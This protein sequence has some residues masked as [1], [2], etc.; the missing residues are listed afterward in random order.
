MAKRYNFTSSQYPM[1]DYEIQRVAPSVFTDQ[2]HKSTSEKFA[3]ITTADIL[4]GLRGEGWNVFGAG[5]TFAKTG[6]REHTKHMLRLRH[7]GDSALRLSDNQSAAEVVLINAH[8]GTS[9]YRMLGGM[10]VFA[11]LNGLVRPGKD[12]MEVRV[13]HSGSAAQ[14]VVEGAFTVL[15]GL[16]RVV[17]ER[18]AMR[19]VTLTRDEQL[20]FARSALQLTHEAGEAP[21]EPVQLLVP[22]RHVDSGSDLWSVFNRVQENTIKGG[23]RGFSTNGRRITTRPVQAIDRSVGLNQALWTLADEMRKLKTGEAVTLEAV[24]A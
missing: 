3:Q 13:R 18:D 15:D 7:S 8:D 9:S 24:L 21:I 10:H 1:T 20:V 6:R 22:R 12:G 19:A 5:Q 23:S 14:R 4:R 16:T 17:E 11:C 2:P